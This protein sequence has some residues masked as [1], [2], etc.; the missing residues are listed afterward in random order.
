MSNADAQLVYARQGLGGGIAFGRKPALLLIDF[1]NGFND[2][3]QLGGGNIG[4]AIAATRPVLRA[5]RD[6]D[7]PIAHTRIVYTETGSDIGVF[8]TKIPGL[9]TLFESA[10]SSQVVDALAPLPGECVIRKKQA[11]AFF[12]TDLAA[13]LR[14]EDADTLVIAGCTTSGCVRA[15]VVDAASHNFRPFVLRDCVGD[16]ALA[17]HEANLFDMGQKY[18]E[19]IDSADLQALLKN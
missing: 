6:R 12:D 10:H 13:W 3:D 2:P 14:K 11:S 19:V 4:D 15:S 18:A 9:Q 17:P 1:V 5:F 7:L 8:A 16:R